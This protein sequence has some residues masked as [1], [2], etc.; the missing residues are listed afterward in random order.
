MESPVRITG[1]GVELTSHEEE[2]IRAT[3][4]KLEHFYNRIVACHVTVSVPNRRPTGEPVAWAVRFTLTVPGGELEVSR[5]LEASF[6]DALDQAYAAARRR[7]E[8][9][10]REIRGDVKAPAPQ[11]EGR[12]TK[13]FGYE[14]YGFV[15]GEDGREIY[16]HQNSVPGGDFA[17]LALGDPVRYVAEEGEQGPQAST[18]VP[19][20]SRHHTARPSEPASP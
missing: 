13:L 2:L 11:A 5:Q 20:V 16:F 12:V 7:L 3:V 1:K 8:D 19:L 10:A 6:K 17:R 4:A 9:H 15:T 14:G 18:V